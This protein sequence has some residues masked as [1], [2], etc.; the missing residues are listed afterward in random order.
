[1]NVEQNCANCRPKIQ[2]TC[3]S[4]YWQSNNGHKIATQKEWFSFFLF[5]VV[6]QRMECQKLNDIGTYI[7][8]GLSYACVH[9]LCWIC[10][11]ERNGWCTV[12]I[13]RFNKCTLC[14]S[15][16]RFWFCL[17]YV[18]VAG[19]L[20]GFLH[21]TLN[22][23]VILISFSECLNAKFYLLPFL[24]LILFF[25]SSTCSSLASIEILD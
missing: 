13:Y 20:I 23:M 14:Y 24:S 3:V 4:L 12:Y 8:S 11:D 7:Q 1:M 19:G 17:W 9:A 18:V 5:C 15:V 25:L 21:E 16:A 10:H 2:R 6:S 22:L